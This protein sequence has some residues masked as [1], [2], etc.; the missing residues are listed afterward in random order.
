MAHEIKNPLTPIQLS[1]ER[2][3]R[4]LLSAGDVSSTNK[5]LIS[6][7]T[8]TITRSVETLRSL[9][10]EFSRFARL[11]KARLEP[12]LV[13]DSV[14]NIVNI[15]SQ[16]NPEVAFPYQLS[17]Q[18]LRV[19]G[20]REQIDAVFTNLFE[21]GVQALERAGTSSPVITTTVEASGDLI[22]FKVA[23]NGAGVPD[24]DKPKL[25][26]P[27]FSTRKGGTG[28]GLAI[29][30]SIIADH[31]GEITV[32]DNFPTGAIFTFTLQRAV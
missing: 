9:V 31:G 25:F 3:Q 24:A 5:E 10:N 12:L 14:R 8:E 15:F 22:I 16:S 11:P 20:D 13:I 21:N 19:L 26:E 28:L 7:T 29:V 6:E 23:D 1:A 2:I 17:S 32:G 18:D 27:Y 4:R 30:S